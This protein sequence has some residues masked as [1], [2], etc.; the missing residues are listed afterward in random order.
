MINPRT[1]T[2]TLTHA[3]HTNNQA[4]GAHHGQKTGDPV[5]CG[6]QGTLGLDSEACQSSTYPTC[7]GFIQGQHM[8][9][10]MLS[11]SAH[12]RTHRRTHARTQGFHCVSTRPLLTPPA[13]TR[14]GRFSHGLA[15][16]DP[17]PTRPQ[18][19]GV[20]AVSGGRKSSFS[21][22]A[23]SRAS[24]FPILFSAPISPPVSSAS[25]SS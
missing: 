15:V 12:L 13:K 11:K 24:D 19:L 22:H 20:E 9:K 10:C 8:G 1:F 25:S 4:C 3:G 14:V 16:A 17:S 18:N 23:P 21:D 7:K 5:C 2:H 6:Q